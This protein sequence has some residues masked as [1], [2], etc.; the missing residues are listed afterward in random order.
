MH[1]RMRSAYVEP[2]DLPQYSVG[3]KNCGQNE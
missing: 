3:G 2:D 1:V